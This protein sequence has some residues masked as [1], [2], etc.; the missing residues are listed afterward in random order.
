MLLI[1]EYRRGEIKNVEKAQK[2]LE[3]E[4]REKKILENRLSAIEDYIQD[5]HLSLPANSKDLVSLR[6]EARINGLE[7]PTSYPVNDK[8]TISRWISW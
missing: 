5:I 3:K 8:K 2:V 1:L 6:Q 4:L 7:L